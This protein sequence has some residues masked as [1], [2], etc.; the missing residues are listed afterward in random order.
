M[1]PGVNYFIRKYVGNCG[2]ALSRDA[3][4]RAQ[5]AA[6]RHRPGQNEIYD[7]APRIMRASQAPKAGRSRTSKQRDERDKSRLRP[8]SAAVPSPP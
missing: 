4:S 2:H 6:I 7:A 5:P 3:S 1:G 8:A